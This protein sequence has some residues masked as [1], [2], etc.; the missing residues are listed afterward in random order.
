MEEEKSYL[1]MAN[2]E[3]KIRVRFLDLSHIV[4]NVHCSASMDISRDYA[5]EEKD[6]I[7]RATINELYRPLSAGI[8]RR[9]SGQSVLNV[10]SFFLREDSNL[11]VAKFTLED[12]KYCF[13]FTKA[14][15]NVLSINSQLV[16]DIK[17][18]G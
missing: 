6:N 11:Y 16:S 1:E 9:I 13:A 3:H 7:T 2:Y 14:E 8:L 5:R 12:G 10:L 18:E 4:F 17:I 15:N